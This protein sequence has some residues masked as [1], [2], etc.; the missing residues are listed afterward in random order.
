MAGS[1]IFPYGCTKP[2]LFR[3]RIPAKQGR[4]GIVFE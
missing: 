3:A 2:T 4:M 1:D